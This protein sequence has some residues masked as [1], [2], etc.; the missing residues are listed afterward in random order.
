MDLD[1][2][3]LA[4]TIPHLV[5]SARSDGFRDYFNERLLNYL[6]R[7]LEEMQG[8]TWQEVLHPD[9]RQRTIA[10]WAEA[11]TRGTEL[12]IEYRIRRGADGVYRWHEGRATPVRDAA[13]NIVRWFGTC[14]DIDERKRA[15]GALAN[16][17]G[18]LERERDILKAVMDGA[19]NFHLVYLDRNFNFVHVNETY[20][21]TCG[22]RPEEL[23]GKNHFALYPH[24]ENETIFARVRDTGEAA[25]F[26]D[27][28]FEFPDHP[29][30]GVTYWSWMLT[31]AKNVSEQVIGLVFSLFETTERKKIET[32]LA[33][34]KEAAEV[35]NRAKSEFLA[36]VSHEIRTP[37][38]GILGMAELLEGT[39]LSACQQGYV[40]TILASTETLL[41][42]VNHILDLSRIEAG[43][44]E[45]ECKEFTLRGIVNEVIGSQILDANAKGLPIN[46]VIP[47]DVPDG[48]IGDPFRLKQILL[49]LVGNAIKFT[50]QGELTLSVV[51]E[52]RQS[53]TALLR[54][55]M[56]DTGIGIKPEAIARIFAPFE[57][58]D[59]SMARKFG[60]TGLGLAICTQLSAL[61]GGEI[62]VD[63]H[64]EGRGST[65]HVRIPF[66]VS[67][68]L[69]EPGGSQQVDLPPLWEGEPRRVLLVEDNEVPRRLFTDLLKKYGH[70]VDV[71]QHGVEALEKLRQADYDIVLMD[72][73]MP[74]MDGIE[75]VGK[76]RELERGQG[77]H[78]PVIAITAYA[79]EKDR[80]DIL[81]K[82]FDGYVSKPTRMKD[83]FNEMKRCLDR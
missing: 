20:A 76:L 14:T 45:L 17:K 78:V 25:E 8:W 1:F 16:A 13:G 29:E 79:M 73:Q 36:N 33:V 34:A 35:A 39:E 19:K 56:T 81:S 57:Q 6:G 62:W 15:E 80:L 82:G 53:S 54:F 23:V 77:R 10:A 66:T 7:T 70:H 69:P 43:K 28:P 2:R 61:L 41:T 32:D 21:R 12:C 75:A 31:P 37:I 58:A 22:Y 47:A 67:H 63:S 27:K 49:N 38:T 42:L 11:K 9:D 4:E 51:V 59:S 26:H 50:D 24:P 68:A 65:F 72:V 55:D 52:K 71:A 46:V 60:G 40:R 3:A 74:V 30:R 18:E 83:L 48:L 5:W 64:G 44:V